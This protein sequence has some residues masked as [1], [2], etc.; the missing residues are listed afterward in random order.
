MYHLTDD[1]IQVYLSKDE[2]KNIDDIKDHLQNCEKCRLNLKTYQQ[3]YTA[4]SNEDVLPTLSRNF[5]QTTIS[6]IE[7]ANDK[8][9]NIFENILIT[10][11]FL[12]SISMSIYFLNLSGIISYFKAIDFSLITHIGNKV[13]NGLS[14]NIFYFIAAMVIIITIELIDRLKIY[15]SIKHVNQ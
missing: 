9:W 8:K 4:L 11:M 2:I 5:A 10:I 1:Q 3:I 6:K 12:I 7:K 14:F 13:I 15:K